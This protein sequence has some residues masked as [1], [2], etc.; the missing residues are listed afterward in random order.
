[1][2]DRDTA[3]DLAKQAGFFL[4]DLHDVDGHDLGESVEADSFDAIERF[5]KLVEKRTAEAER[6]PLTDKQIDALW[7]G[8]KVS[9]PQRINRRAISRSIE[10]AHGIGASN[11][12]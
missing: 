8:E 5:A 6:K 9:L 4:Y 1:M 7:G 12:R 10:R 2:I 11:A 3:I